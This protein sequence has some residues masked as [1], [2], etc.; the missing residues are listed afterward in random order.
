MEWLQA[1]GVYV[2]ML[3]ESIPANGKNALKV[4]WFRSHS[5]QQ[6]GNNI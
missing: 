3:R 1:G 4:S 2:G 6:S 5:E